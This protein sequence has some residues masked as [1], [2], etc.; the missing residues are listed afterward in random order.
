MDPSLGGHPRGKEKRSPNGG[1]PLIEAGTKVE[2]L[3]SLLY[4]QITWSLA[5]TIFDKLKGV[6]MLVLEKMFYNSTV[7]L[8]YEY[9][10]E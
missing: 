8:S 7:S 1:V 5:L 6:Q 4:V 2:A 3:P 10:L 9:F